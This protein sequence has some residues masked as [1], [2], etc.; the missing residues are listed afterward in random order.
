M[1]KNY[2]GRTIVSDMIDGCGDVV[3][4]PVAIKAIRAVCKYFGGQLLYIP[5]NKTS[6]ATTGELLGCICDAVGYGD[7]E[8]IL[9]KLMALYGGTQI[10]VPMEKGAFRSIIAREIYERYDNNNE[11]IRDLCRDYQ[12]SFTQVYRLWVE[13]RANKAQMQFEFEG[14]KNK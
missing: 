9:E 14:G 2:D 5:R 3:K 8:K 7:G 13:G 12:M 1:I 11:S 6:G 10:Y 4:K